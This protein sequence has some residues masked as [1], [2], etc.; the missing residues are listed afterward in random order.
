MKKHICIICACQVKNQY[1]TQ[2]TLK[3]QIPNAKTVK[4]NNNVNECR[5]HCWGKRILFKPSY[6]IL[7]K[8]PRESHVLKIRYV[9]I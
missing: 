6:P 5:R 7:S 3:K 1:R 2:K 8:I 9:V 4:N